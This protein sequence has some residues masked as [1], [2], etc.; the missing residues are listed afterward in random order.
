[1]DRFGKNL[2]LEPVFFIREHTNM[3][4]EVAVDLHE[5]QGGKAVEPCVGNLLHNLPVSFILNLGNKRLTLFFLVSG[6]N[7]AI[8]TVSRGIYHVVLGN[9]ILFR[10]HGNTGD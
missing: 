7:L 8:H 2:G 9:A 1:M 3:R 5:T 6:Q 10:F 4:G